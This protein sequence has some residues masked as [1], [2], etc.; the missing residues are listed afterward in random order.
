MRIRINRSPDRDLDPDSLNPDPDPGI[1]LNPD[2]VAVAESGSDS[3]QKILKFY[4]LYICWMKSRYK[5]LLKLI[6][7]NFFLCW[8]T[9]LAFLDPD[10]LAQINP[11]PKNWA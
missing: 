3:R 6:F 11:D 8:G 9:I 4:N 2:S 5:C 1:L 10:L 7:L